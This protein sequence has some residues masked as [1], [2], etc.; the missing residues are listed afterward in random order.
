MGDQG[1]QAKCI[2]KIHE[3]KRAGKILV[4]VSH[5]PQVLRQ[6]CDRALWLE[7]GRLVREGPVE[8]TLDAY[9]AY[10]TVGAGN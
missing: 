5:A 4:C 2:E 10:C 3:L 1:F 7:S 9:Q 6:L 8:E